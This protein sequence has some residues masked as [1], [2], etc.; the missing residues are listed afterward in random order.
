[1]KYFLPGLLNYSIGIRKAIF[2]NSPYCF[3]IWFLTAAIGN[4]KKVLIPDVVKY[5]SQNQKQHWMK[6]ILWKV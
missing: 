2:E 6:G 1:M 4:G 3:L 5:Y